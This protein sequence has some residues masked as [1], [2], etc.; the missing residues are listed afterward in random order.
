MSEAEQGPAESQGQAL[1]RKVEA[2]LSNRFRRCFSRLISIVIATGVLGFGA[3]LLWGRMENTA[4]TRGLILVETPQVYTRERLVNDRFVQ[5]GWLRKLL[6]EE[7]SFSIVDTVNIVRDQKTL[8]ATATPPQSTSDKPTPPSDSNARATE[9]KLNLPP[10][11]HFYMRNAYRELIRSHLIENQLDD[12]HDIRGTTI[13]MVKFDTS[14]L[15]GVNTKSPAVIRAHI[16]QRQHGELSQIKRHKPEDYVKFFIEKSESFARVSPSEADRRLADYKLYEDWRQSLRDRLNI[17]F[18]EVLG[19]F[20]ANNFRVSEYQH[21]FTMIGEGSAKDLFNSWTD[22]FSKLES[23]YRA[24]RGKESICSKPDAAAPASRTSPKATKQTKQTLKKEHKLKQEHELKQDPDW[25]PGDHSQAAVEGRFHLLVKYLLSE[26]APTAAPAA[27]RG[28]VAA[29]A[30]KLNFSAREIAR[31]LCGAMP[32]PVS[33]PEDRAVAERKLREALLNYVIRRVG[34]SVVGDASFR[35]EPFRPDR[36]FEFGRR[37][38]LISSTTLNPFVLIGLNETVSGS[39]EFEVVPWNSSFLAVG[40]FDEPPPGCQL[41]SPRSS[42]RTLF[43][44]EWFPQGRFYENENDES[45]RNSPE[46][47]VYN[48]IPPELAK[49]TPHELLDDANLR[50]AFGRVIDSGLAAPAYFGPHSVCYRFAKVVSFP[51]GYFNF[52]RGIFDMQTYTY[53]TLP[54]LDL[55]LAEVAED[56]TRDEKLSVDAPGRASG[57]LANYYRKVARAVEPKT[58]VVGFSGSCSEFGRPAPD[59]SFWSSL[60]PRSTG[61]VIAKSPPSVAA[62]TPPPAPLQGPA[63]LCDGSAQSDE[64]R[65]G[66]VLSPPVELERNK[67]LSYR[68][69]QPT[70]RSLSALITVPSWWKTA[71]ISIQTG[72]LDDKGLFIRTGGQEYIVTLPIDY[73]SLDTILVGPARRDSHRPFVATERMPENLEVEACEKAEVLIPGRRLWR[74]TMVMLGGQRANDVVVL[75]DMRGIIATF[76]YVAPR[77]TSEN[78]DAAVRQLQVWTSE[79][80][81]GNMEV[82]V[83]GKRRDCLPKMPSTVGSQATQRQ[84]STSN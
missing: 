20:N 38:R 75:P 65:F 37:T 35:L 74:S 49:L 4:V 69:M 8:I 70:Q 47:I 66:W 29:S 2:S 53:A 17:V 19:R 23:Q 40:L 33:K 72:W 1:P 54:R 25:L 45:G 61:E 24:T 18:A 14:I 48:N 71:H 79:G 30:A 21:V 13:Y 31:M 34:M 80:M 16:T 11:L 82:A 52:V 68:A 64:L 81:A 46:I 76:D 51:M 7:P 42:L 43:G 6:E 63:S 67:S 56:A 83:K 59:Q 77:G 60:S 39:F 27:A 41:Q 10:N 62:S 84:P 15:P 73:E 78:D 3:Y 12:R 58:G 9:P 28:P 22:I 44:Q 55:Q 36:V 32:L 50:L 5:E 26:A 57:T